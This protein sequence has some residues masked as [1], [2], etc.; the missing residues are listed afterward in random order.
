MNTVWFYAFWA[1]TA[2]HFVL[3]ALVGFYFYEDDRSLEERGLFAALTAIGSFDMVL[4]VLAS[5]IG[6]Q[7]G[8]GIVVL[9]GTSAGMAWAL[10]RLRR[11]RPA[12]LT[13][14]KLDPPGDPLA[15]L[16]ATALVGA[17]LSWLSRA[18]LSDRIGGL[19]ALHYH[20]PHALS[21]AN[22][23]T[24][25]GAPATPH[26][27]P[28]THSLV[29]A[30]LFV[31]DHSPLVVDLMNLPAFVLIF[32]CFCCLFRVLTG[33]SGFRWMPWVCFCCFAT[34]LLRKLTSIGADLSYAAAFLAL[35]SLLTVA[36][37]R[38]RVTARHWLG[39]SLAAGLLLGSK[40][41]GI[42][43]LVALVAAFSVCFAWRK[44]SLKPS[45]CGPAFGLLC[46]FIVVTSGGI[47]LL[48]SWY[49]FGSPIAPMGLSLFG[50]T[51]FDGRD[52]AQAK[53]YHSV[54]QDL[55]R[56]DYDLYGDLKSYLARWIGAEYAAILPLFGGVALNAALGWR[57]G[58]AGRGPRPGRSARWSDRTVVLLIALVST[59][60]H[61]Y[62]VARAPWS[63][64]PRYQGLTLR[65]LLPSIVLAFPLAFA[66]ATLPN[67]RQPALRWASW[68]A[69]LLLLAFTADRVFGP[70]GATEAYRFPSWPW[71]VLA[72]FIL[73][74]W[75]V[76]FSTTSGR[77]LRRLGIAAAAVV[78]GATLVQT[79]RVSRELRR[80]R[81]EQHAA[82]LGEFRRN[83][84]VG[85]A[86]AAADGS[87]LRYALELHQLRAGEPC[88]GRR[89]LLAD[90]FDYPLLLQGPS[91]RRTVVD[92]SSDPLRAAAAKG[93]L[94]IDLHC[95]AVVA[96]AGRRPAAVAALLNAPDCLRL[97][98]A[99]VK[100]AL[101][102]HHAHGTADEP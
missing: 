83:A 63:S 48:R 66:S 28:M 81:H 1:A 67:L 64:L 17:C 16:G 71:I 41:L 18:G 54:L 59:A 87:D 92:L 5:T 101:F 60:M 51:I 38:R 58:S 34:P 24:L 19:D 73:L 4:V 77:A 88:L 85:R 86:P 99:G 11:R 98:Y 25:F 44:C 42:V 13:V 68:G 76:A 53:Y 27:Y 43:S 102:V 94:S 32:F 15:F 79:E 74:P 70:Y 89:V 91:Y 72:G 2:A 100:Y 23:N 61:A 55:T 26:M 20:V 7:R 22:G 50:V 93:G 40:T 62:F 31:G 46:L 96:Q 6:I 95:D 14:S 37:V 82:A 56:P 33:S 30:W 78:I 29:G 84:A 69:M 12:R 21:Y 9:L 8:T 52:P 80:I 3:A 35:F 36:L 10:R 49:L 39:L 90:R 75:Q 47:W 45:S 57:A 65:Y 97:A